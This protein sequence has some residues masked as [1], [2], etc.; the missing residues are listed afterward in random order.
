MKAKQCSYTLTRHSESAQGS[1]PQASILLVRDQQWQGT[2][3][4]PL[5]VMRRLKEKWKASNFPTMRCSV[6]H[7]PRLCPIRITMG[8]QHRKCWGLLTSPDGQP[9]VGFLLEFHILQM[10]NGGNICVSEQ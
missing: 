7:F 2:E 9:R 8:V 1:E 4:F 6:I 3:M 10:N 5:D